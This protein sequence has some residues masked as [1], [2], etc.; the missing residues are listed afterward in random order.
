MGKRVL[1][2]IMDGWGMSS[3][4]VKDAT[5]TANTPNIDKYNANEKHT[6]IFAE[7]II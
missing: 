5:K 1:L 7:G 3:G 6:Q 4:C 2:C